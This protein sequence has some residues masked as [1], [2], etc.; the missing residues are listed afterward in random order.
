MNANP[1]RNHE[2]TL[3]GQLLWSDQYQNAVFIIHIFIK[4]KKKSGKT[5]FENLERV[6]RSA[7]TI[8]REL[9]NILDCDELPESH[10]S[11]PEGWPR[12]RAV[13]LDNKNYIKETS[14][15]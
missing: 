6:Q 12:S 11:H 3:H 4:V 10:L 7:M 13:S 2:T 15:F 14:S 9:E 8:H 1:S 5:S